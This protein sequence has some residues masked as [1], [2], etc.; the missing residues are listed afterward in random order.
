MLRTLKIILQTLGAFKICVTNGAIMRCR[1]H[2]SNSSGGCFFRFFHWNWNSMI[3]L[4]MQ[5]KVSLAQ[6][7]FTHS[8]FY[9]FRHFRLLLNFFQFMYIIV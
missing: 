1:G 6:Y 3:L 4:H 2:R 7:T 9:F 8:A 5:C